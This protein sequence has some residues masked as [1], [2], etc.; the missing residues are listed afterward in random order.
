MIRAVAACAFLLLGS[1]YS[2][3]HGADDDGLDG[4]ADGEDGEHSGDDGPGEDV[5]L[6]DAVSCPDV[7]CPA[8]MALVPCGPF[9][10]G[11][12]VDDE[13]LSCEPQHIV[14]LSTYCIDTTE[15]TRQQFEACMAAGACTEAAL[16]SCASR[17]PD[18]PATCVSW[19]MAAAF[20]AWAGKRLPTEAEWEKAARGG[21]EVVS[22][23]ECG[24]EDKRLF[25]WGDAPCDCERANVA[26]CVDYVDTVGIRPFG[27]SPYGVLDMLGNVSE[28]VADC[29]D[30]H[31]YACAG[32]CADPRGPTGACA[33][34]VE[35]GANFQN[36][37]ADLA[38]RG[39]TGI[40]ARIGNGFR[41]ALTPPP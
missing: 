34:H 8:G 12:V 32:G 5:D 19:D 3:W 27:A 29:Y 13:E 41:C 14:W 26:G 36:S 38:T 10:M 37:P 21:C 35:R 33:E 23:P 22:P 18:H 28:A 16:P 39:T 2:S 9:V 7:S 25:P 40:Y 15:V 17:V 31:Y 11:C 20:C 6:S 24:P 1:C 30:D 4:S